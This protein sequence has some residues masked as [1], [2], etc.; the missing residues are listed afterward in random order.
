MLAKVASLRIVLQTYTAAFTLSLPSKP[1]M[2][3]GRDTWGRGRAPRPGLGVRGPLMVRGFI[4]VVLLGATTPR[5]G[6]VWPFVVDRLDGVAG[7]S[8]PHVVRPRLADFEKRSQCV[9]AR[10][11]LYASKILSCV[12]CNLRS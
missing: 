3:V 10:L 2:R 4:R 7:N 5:I 6:R 12:V 1:S 8:Y 9:K 11:L